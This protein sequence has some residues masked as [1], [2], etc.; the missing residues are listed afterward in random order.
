[1]FL[2]TLDDNFPQVL[3][4]KICFSICHS[5]DFAN[6]VPLQKTWFWFPNLLSPMF[7]VFDQEMFIEAP[8]SKWQAPRV[9][10]PV[11]L[12]FQM[13]GKLEIYESEVKAD[14]KLCVNIN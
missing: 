5:S 12:V 4:C 11:S 2:L 6:S 3:T 13:L 8:L 7:A 1:M 9:A 10:F 14:L